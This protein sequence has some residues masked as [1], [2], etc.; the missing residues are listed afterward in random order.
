M[1]GEHVVVTG[2]AGYV[3]SHTCK[4]LARAGLVPV[5]YDNLS[6]GHQ[7]AVQWGPFEYGDILDR[8]RLSAVLRQYAA[9]GVIHFAAVS[10]VGESVVDPAKYYWN[11]VAGTVSMVEAMREAGVDKLIS[12]SSC[13]V[14]GLSQADSIPETH[15]MLPV[16][17]YGTSKQMMETVL[18][19][20]G[21]A[22][23]IESISLRYFNAAGADHEGQIGE[24]HAPETHLIPLVLFAAAGLSEELSIYGTDYNT[25]DGTCIRDFIHVCDLADAHI[26]ALKALISGA[27]TNVYNLGNGRGYSILE[28]VES[29]KRVTG[30]PVKT[31]V[32]QRRRGDPDCLIGDSRRV[33]SELGWIP[34]YP[35]I[36]PIIESAWRWTL[37]HH[38]P[39]VLPVAKAPSLSTD[40]KETA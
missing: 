30:R 25:P 24:D 21:D 39:G 12:S 40:P 1:G 31:V 3:G 5:A 8:T 33:R 34:Q 20:C 13:S 4:A 23:G 14:Y 36:D 32:R 17:P 37:C 26:L 22:Y 28:V 19:D 29:V 7:W 38:L 27:K 18:A 16:N 6:T 15:G 10:S 35:G 2:G 9:I 11:N